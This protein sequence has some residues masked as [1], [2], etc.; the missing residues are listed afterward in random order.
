MLTIDLF[1]LLGAEGS[2]GCVFWA[3]QVPASLS[4]GLSV[5]SLALLDNSKERYNCFDRNWSLCVGQIPCS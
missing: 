3:T 4:L 2:A 1:L 5:Q